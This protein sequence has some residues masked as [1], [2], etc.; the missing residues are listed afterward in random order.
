QFVGSAVY[1]AA[2]DAASGQPHR[3]PVVI[4]VPAVD[5]ALV[6]SGRRQLDRR[7]SAEFPA[8]DDQRL[9]EQAA[10]FQ[11]LEQG[12]DSLVALFGEAAVVNLDVVMAIPGLPLAVPDLDEADAALNE[13]AG[14][15][16]LL[17][18]RAGA[19]HIANMLRLLTHVEGVGRLHLHTIGQLE[20]LNAGVD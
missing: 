2:L 8:P 6:G 20:G 3:K 16:D 1:V 11:V 15:E 5:L 14:D 18:L 10:L 17:G 7:R 13:P 9:V 19:V 4:V 12:A